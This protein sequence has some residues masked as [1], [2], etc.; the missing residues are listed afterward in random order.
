M[1]LFM[2]TDFVCANL[3]KGTEMKLNYIALPL[4][5]LVWGNS[6][7]ADSSLS[8]DRQKFSYAIGL[9]IGQDFKRGELDIDIN[10]FTT[11]I[12]DMIAGKNPRLSPEEMQAAMDVLRQQQMEKQ[13]KF[14]DKN[15]AAG[16]AFLAAN[17]NK[18]GV[19]TLE[20]GVQ[21]KVIASGSGKT[22]TKTD[23]VVVH[24][25]GTFIDGTEFD[26]SIARGKPLTFPVTGVIKGWTELLLKMK[27][28]DKWQA[29]IPSDSAY[30]PRGQG[31]VIGPNSTL[32]FDIELIEVKK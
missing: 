27:E 18:A 10:A 17:K 8:T 2:H 12:N 25:R 11:A 1:S 29:Y 26:S 28:G 24:Y 14:A 20:S 19:K 5:A 4:A 9:Q 32:I 6:F 31:Q 23:S 21:Y 30:G 16:D 15:K 22:P 13:S 3:T 7:A